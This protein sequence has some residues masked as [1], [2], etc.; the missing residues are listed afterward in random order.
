MGG[1]DREDPAGRMPE[2]DSGPPMESEVPGTKINC[3]IESPPQNRGF[4]Y[5]N[6]GKIK[7]HI[8]FTWCLWYLLY[9]LKRCNEVELDET[10]ICRS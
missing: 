2:E 9:M 7:I 8:F 1:R 6:M 3:F 10:A 4:F 5:L